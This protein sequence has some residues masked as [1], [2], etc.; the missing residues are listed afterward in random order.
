MVSKINN[1]AQFNFQWIFAIVAGIAIL[2]LAIYGVS[3]ISDSQRYQTDTEIAKKISIITDPL[4]AGFAEGKFGEIQFRQ[5]TRMSN[6]CL[7]SGGDFGKNEVSVSTRSRIGEEWNMAGGATSIYN[8]YLFS[9][10]NIEGDD[11]YV[12]S[13]TFYL[14]FKIADLVIIT[15]DS[16]EYCFVGAPEIFVDEIEGLNL[17]NVHTENCSLIDEDRLETVCFGYSPECDVVIKGDCN[18]NCGEYGIY[19]YGIV[20]DLNKNEEKKYVGNL[21]WG[22]IFSEKIVYDCDVERLLFRTSKISEV[23]AEKA[24]LMDSRGCSTNLN[25]DMVLLSEMTAEGDSDD[26]ISIY[27]L[28]KDIDYKNER[29]LCGLW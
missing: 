23:L 3:R 17:K 29:E 4:Q 18:M 20:E 7:K 11:F 2:A 13:K 28:S 9:Y 15:S 27:G 26:L 14:P 6:V 1:K 19:D 5:T 10:E 16:K 22:A 12:L 24:S 21:L 8:K 25:G